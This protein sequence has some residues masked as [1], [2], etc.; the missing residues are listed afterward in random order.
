MALRVCS[1][2]GCHENWAETGAND[3]RPNCM[4]VR[5]RPCQYVDS[6]LPRGIPGFTTP[7]QSDPRSSSPFLGTSAVGAGASRQLLQQP[8]TP[9]AGLAAAPAG[10]ALATPAWNYGTAGYGRSG[11]ASYSYNGVDWFE[12]D[13]R[14][15]PFASDDGSDDD[16]MGGWA[17][18]MGTDRP[19]DPS[20]TDRAAPAPAGGTPTTPFAT[21]ATPTRPGAPT[22]ME[23]VAVADEGQEHL[24]LRPCVDCGRRTG[25]FCDWCL[26][27]DRF[28]DEE[29][30][31]GQHT[32]LCT[33]CDRHHN[34]CHLCRGLVWAAP[35]PHGAPH[36]A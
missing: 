31:P 3:T 6:F 29:W 12:V 18:A 16:G 10:T 14:D 23:V 19:T 11:N 20:P 34:Q 35:P 1:I 13:R 24:L 22:P 28:P 21:A 9:V 27:T 25:C 7:Y 5:G 2:C 17:W 30:V 32:P 15:D 33:I 36:G 8:L 4:N 26:A